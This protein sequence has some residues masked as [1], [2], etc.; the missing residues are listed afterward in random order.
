MG[1]GDCAKIEEMAQEGRGDSAEVPKTGFCEEKKRFLK[2]F[3]D[4]IHELVEMQSQQTQAV[5]DGDPDFTRFDVLLHMAHDRKEQAK[6]ALMA[7]IEAHR[8]EEA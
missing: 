4:A 6:Y 2:E 3:L 7:H 1:S 5:I 8:C